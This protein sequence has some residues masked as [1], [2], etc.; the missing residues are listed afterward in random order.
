MRH[1]QRRR[2]PSTT[3]ASRGPPLS[4]RADG[5]SASS[6]RCTA[7]GTAQRHP[8]DCT[9]RG[10]TLCCHGL[11]VTRSLTRH[12]LT[13]LHCVRACVWLPPPLPLLFPASL[14]LFLVS[15]TRRHVECGRRSG[16]ARARVVGV[17]DIS[18][19]GRVL[20]LRV[21]RPRDAMLQ[22]PHRRLE[23]LSHADHIRR[24][25]E[26][27]HVLHHPAARRCRTDRAGSDPAA[28]PAQSGTRRRRR[29]HMHARASRSDVEMR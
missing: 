15:F 16:Q 3:V 11:S 1:G 8:D 7:I 20:R 10:A 23:E 13:P 17:V 2:P 19:R 6:M 9:K 26:V 27:R 5:Q 18:L 4:H 22:L 28:V 21:R 25:V 12:S 14:A 29:S 24:C